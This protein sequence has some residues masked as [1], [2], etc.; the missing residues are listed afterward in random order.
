VRREDL[1]KIEQQADV[2]SPQLQCV[3]R[4]P[5]SGDW[6]GMAQLAAQLGYECTGEEVRE[7][8]GGMQDSKDYAVYVAELPGGQI[9][10]WIGVFVFRGVTGSSAEIAGLVID[11]RVRSCGIGKMLLG[12]AEQWARS[13]R[14]DAIWVRSDVKR[15]RAHHFYTNNGFEHLKTQKSFRKGLSPG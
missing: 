12:A 8:V 13:I 9:A 11:E 14:R 1:L 15:D 5:R 2:Y 6:D 4:P 3:V 10:G 7:R